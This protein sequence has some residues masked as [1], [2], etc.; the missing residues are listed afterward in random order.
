MPAFPQ[1]AGIFLHKEVDNINF[2]GQYEKLS[3]LKFNCEFV[4][5]SERRVEA[6]RNVGFLLIVSECILSNTKS[7]FVVRWL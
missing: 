7:E 2:I 5:S 3:Q 1:N 4:D 6:H